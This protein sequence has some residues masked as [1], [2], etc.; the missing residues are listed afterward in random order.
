MKQSLFVVAVLG[1]LAS[2]SFAQSS[3]TIYGVA[4]AGIEYSKGLASEEKNWR[5][6]SGQQSGNRLG[7]R[8]TEALGGG[9]SAIFTLESGFNIDDGTLVSSNVLFSRQA[10]VGLSGGFGSVKLGRQQ[11]PLYDAQL[12]VDP[13]GINLAG[14]MQRVFGSGLY[15]TDPLF[16][17]D[18][19]IMYATPDFAGFTGQLAYTL[20]EQPG[21]NSARRQVEAGLSYV[22]G[23]INAKFVYHDGNDVTLGELGTGTADFRTAFIGGTYD[24]KVAKAH[25]AFGDS[26]AKAATD[27]DV[28]SLLIGA[29]APVGVGTVLASYIRNDV[30]DFAEGVTDQYAIGYTHDLSK[31][32][33]LYT[34]FAYIKNDSGVSVRAFANGENSR[35]FNA[36]IRHRF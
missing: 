26:K 28:R 1:S 5:L 13:F 27:V 6:Q 30:R 36:G 35:V 17:A 4:D 21:D 18:N 8:G 32:T 10:W 2:A 3:V 15:G 7:F 23:P 9:L 24:F 22:N 11:T 14:G 16:R 20:G 12:A 25:L 19:T 31:R 29:S 34:S 33:N